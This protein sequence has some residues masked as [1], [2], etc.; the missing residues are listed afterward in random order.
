LNMMIKEQG[1]G[2]HRLSD[3]LYQNVDM[4]INK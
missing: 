1:F 3:P 4:M 2:H